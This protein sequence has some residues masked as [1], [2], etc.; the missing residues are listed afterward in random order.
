MNFKS[1]KLFYY[2]LLAFSTFTNIHSY[3]TDMYDDEL[4][5]RHNQKQKFIESMLEK[6]AVTNLWRTTFNPLKHQETVAVSIVKTEIDGQGKQVKTNVNH[7]YFIAGMRQAKNDPQKQEEIRKKFIEALPSDS[8]FLV[9]SNTFVPLE[10]V[11][12]TFEEDGYIRIKYKYKASPVNGFT[13]TNGRNEYT[14]E[15]ETLLDQDDFADYTLII[16]KIADLKE[17]MDKLRL[18]DDQDY[19]E[20]QPIVPCLWSQSDEEAYALFLKEKELLAQK[21]Q[22]STSEKAEEEKEKEKEKEKGKEKEQE[23]TIENKQESASQKAQGSISEKEAPLQKKQQPTPK[24]QKGEE[25]EIEIKIIEKKQESPPT[26]YD[27][28]TYNPLNLLLDCHNT[29]Q[30]VVKEYTDFRFSRLAKLAE[31][32]TLKDQL[33]EENKARLRYFNLQVLQYRQYLVKTAKKMAILK[34]KKAYEKLWET[35]REL[36]SNAGRYKEYFSQ[37]DRD[38]ARGNFQAWH[39]QIFK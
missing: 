39:H 33:S 4:Q 26:K 20:A 17:N 19:T 30:R 22:E 24:K 37:F 7:N 21:K 35:L 18:L 5:Y 38:F 28:E 13:W 9:A 12:K 23:I 36:Q 25:E 32:S 27:P 11:D 10:V 6:Y 29:V 2:S 16:N 3:A 34:E 15:V 1:K 8:Y 31:Y 14:F